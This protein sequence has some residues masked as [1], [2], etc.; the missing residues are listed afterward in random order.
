M[1]HTSAGS[2]PLG[3]GLKAVWGERTVNVHLEWT[4]SKAFCFMAR[5]W[6]APFIASHASGSFKMIRRILV[7]FNTYNIMIYVLGEKIA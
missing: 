7:T 2:E 5:D 3:A 1:P 4:L 6:T